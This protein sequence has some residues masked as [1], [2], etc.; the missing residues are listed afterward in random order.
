MP[1]RERTSLSQCTG[2]DARDLDQLS[3]VGPAPALDG[4]AVCQPALRCIAE[5]SRI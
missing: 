1:D 3:A 2:Q 5:L 4:L